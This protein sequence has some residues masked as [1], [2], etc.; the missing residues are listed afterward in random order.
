MKRIAMGLMLLAFGSTVAADEYVSVYPST[1]AKY[2]ERHRK[3]ELFQF[4]F[5]GSAPQNTLDTFTS[6]EP[7]YQRDNFS[8]PPVYPNLLRRN[9][10]R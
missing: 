2:T 3:I 5:E 6:Q 9:W 4:R 7:D 8:N 1:D 10:G